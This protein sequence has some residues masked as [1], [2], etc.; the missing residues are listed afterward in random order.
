VDRA[1]PAAARAVVDFLTGE[2]FEP[3]QD[4]GDRTLWVPERGVEAAVERRLEGVGLQRV[5]RLVAAVVEVPGPAARTH[6][7]LEADVR[8]PLGGVRSGGPV[9]AGLV[10]GGAAATVEPLL[11]AAVVAAGA[12]LGGLGWRSARAARRRAAGDVRAVLA[13]FLE[14]LA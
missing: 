3:R 8:V 11:G 14:W 2:L 4:L 7:R 9:A 13:G 5:D 1:L 12:V 6:V 10:A